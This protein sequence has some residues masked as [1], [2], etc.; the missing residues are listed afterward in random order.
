MYLLLKYIYKNIKMSHRNVANMQN[1]L[2]YK[3]Q[4]KNEKTICLTMIVR[5]ES[6]NMVRLLNSVKPIIDFISIV[7]TGSTDNTINVIDNWCKQN[8]IPHKIHQEP[9]QDFAYNRTH[10]VQ[11]AKQS[12]PHVD[13]FLLSDADFIWEIDVGTKFNKKLLFAHKIL[14]NQY[15]DN[16]SYSNIRL[17]SNL[18]DWVC[19]G[20]THEYFKEA[21]VQ[22]TFKGEVQ[23]A[24]VKTIR[25]KDMEDGGHKSTKYERD[26]E[27]LTR[28]LNDPKTPE[29][30]KV[31]YTFYLGQTQKCLGNF[32]ESIELY[33]KRIA[34]GHWLEEQFVSYHQIGICYESWAAYIKQAQHIIKKENQSEADKEYIKKWNPDDLNLEQLKERE[35]ELTEL[36]IKWYLD[37]W[38]FRP[39]R[40]ESLHRCCSVLRTIGRYRECYLYAIEG[41]KIPY[42]SDQLFLEPNSYTWGFDFE[43]SIVCYYIGKIT[44]GASA[45]ESL[46]ERSDLPANVR[47]RVEQNCKFYI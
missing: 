22:S 36:A 46:L 10:S 8:K 26:L 7:D 40:A 43:L 2:R 18:V 16:I 37:G 1:K 4:T 38:K 3:L 29:D 41:N 28:G 27:L 11:M 33:T 23:A 44:D 12:F 35:D 42:S 30:L 47:S 17:L 13:Y 45:C 31:R 6:K 9:F 5:N 14:V 39:S 25:I 34:M 15:N 32:K 21:D 19:V 20:L 24:Q